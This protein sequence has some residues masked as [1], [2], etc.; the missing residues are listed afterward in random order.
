MDSLSLVTL[1]L[2]VEEKVFDELGVTITIADDKAM[3]QKRSPFR[4][5]SS[6]AEYANT[7]IQG[8][9]NG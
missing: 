8:K 7:L 4:N 9:Q 2:I 6:L 1:I 3:S 5:V